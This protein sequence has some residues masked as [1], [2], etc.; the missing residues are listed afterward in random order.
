MKVTLRD[1]AGKPIPNMENEFTITIK[2]N[3][4]FDVSECQTATVDLDTKVREEFA[5]SFKDEESHS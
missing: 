5:L 4:A 2:D 3:A 1:S